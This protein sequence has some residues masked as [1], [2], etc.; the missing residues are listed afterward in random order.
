MSKCQKDVKLSK[1]CQIVKKMSNC[2]KDVNCQKIKHIDYG[3]GSQK[4][5]DIM[6]FTHIDVTY[7]GH[8]KPSKTL[9]HPFWGFLVTI[10]CDVKNWRQCVWTSWQFIFFVNLLHSLCV[11][12]FDIW[13]LFD[14]LTSFWQFDIFLT[15][16]CLFD[17]WTMGH[18][19]KGVVN[20]AHRG[21]APWG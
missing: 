19:G 8:R 9:S 14:N 5:I 7:D 17:T 18:M 16:W 1:R 15:T 12:L 6:R 13:H 4:K 2:Q 10:I 21:E 11:W 3:R 20:I